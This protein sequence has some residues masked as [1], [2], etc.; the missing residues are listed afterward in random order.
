MPET[1]FLPNSLIQILMILLGIVI[2]VAGRKLFWVTLG[3]AGFIFGLLLTFNVLQDQPAWLILILALVIGFIGAFVAVIM[4]KAVV[5][6]AGLLI[7]G[8][9][10]SAL[11]LAL[12][13]DL[14]QWQWLAYIIGAVIGFVVLIAIFEVGLVILSAMLGAMLILQVINLESWLEGLLLIILTIVGVIIQLRVTS[15]APPP[16]PSSP[17]VSQRAKRTR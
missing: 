2:L 15:P 5:A 6:L 8:Y 12:N 7:G 4:Q 1:I 11:L 10:F 16:P 17:P 3:V 14:A 13:P 9:L